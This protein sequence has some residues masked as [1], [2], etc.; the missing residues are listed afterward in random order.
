MAAQTNSKVDKVS[1]PA[2]SLAILTYKGEEGRTCAFTGQLLY[3][4]FERG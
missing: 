2:A 3:E 4:K 1:E